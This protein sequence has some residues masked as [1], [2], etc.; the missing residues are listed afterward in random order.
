M[1][2]AYP[3]PAAWSGGLCVSIGILVSLYSL[4]VLIDWQRYLFNA[5]LGT[6]IHIALALYWWIMYPLKQALRPSVWVLGV[7]DGSRATGP[8][9]YVWTAHLKETTDSVGANAP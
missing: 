3:S 7:I 8:V 4:P 9:S 5:I 2:S 6:A 1:C